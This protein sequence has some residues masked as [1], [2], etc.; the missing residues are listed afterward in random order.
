MSSYLNQERK[1]PSSSTVYK[2]KQ[3]N[4]VLNMSVDFEVVGKQGM[5][6]LTGGSIMNSYFGQTNTDSSQDV[7]WWTGVMWITCELKSLHTESGIVVQ[8]LR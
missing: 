4:T 2:W 6:F 3:P 8:N 5:G 7:H 1:V